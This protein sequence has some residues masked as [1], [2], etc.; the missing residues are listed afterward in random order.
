VGHKN[1][2]P[3]TVET[4]DQI[5]PPSE[6]ACDYK[7]ADHIDRYV[8]QGEPYDATDD[9]SRSIDEA[10]GEIRNRVAAGGE[11]WNPP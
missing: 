1:S 8:Q 9:F 7:D 10:Y 11:G 4:G 2:W 3:D 5:P 6:A